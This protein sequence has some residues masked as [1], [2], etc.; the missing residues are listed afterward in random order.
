M[1]LKEWVLEPE[2]EYRFELDPGTSLAITACLLVHSSPVFLPGDAQV[3]RGTA[4]IFGAEL[5]ARRT[6]LFGYECKAA[7]F[8]W[9]G[10]TLEM[11]NAAVLAPA[12]LQYYRSTFAAGPRQSM[13]QTR[14]TCGPA[15]TCTSCLRKC[16]YARAALSVDLQLPT[17]AATL[18]RIRRA[19]SYWDRKTLARRR[20]VR[21]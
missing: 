14:Q 7:I 16:A 17:S 18:L 13:S 10:C 19:S 15:Q 4:E 20:S 6:Y 5:A 8:T 1:E 3:V 21:Y 11:S 12:C 9:E 2:S